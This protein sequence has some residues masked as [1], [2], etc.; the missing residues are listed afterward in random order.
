MGWR[1]NKLQP[2]TIKSLPK[3]E[4][5]SSL[6]FF[7]RILPAIHYLEMYNLTETKKTAIFIFRLLESVINPFL[8][9]IDVIITNV[10]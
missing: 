5:K 4:R 10:D 1:V 8:I 3:L 9:S 7:K 6:V 2:K